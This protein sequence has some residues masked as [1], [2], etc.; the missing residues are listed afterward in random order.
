MTQEAIQQQI[1]AIRKASA[2]ASKS[3][4]AARK[5]LIDAGIIKGSRKKEIKE[6]EKKK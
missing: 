3:P 4:E 6:P 1:E 2:D 5:F